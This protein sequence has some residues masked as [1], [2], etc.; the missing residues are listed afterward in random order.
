MRRFESEREGIGERIRDKTAASKR[1]C[2]GCLLLALQSQFSEHLAIFRVE[3]V[4]HINFARAWWEGRRECRLNDHLALPLRVPGRES[5]DARLANNHEQTQSC[6][7]S[8]FIWRMSDQ[9]RWF[10]RENRRIST[11]FFWRL[12][13]FGI[14]AP[15]C[16]KRR[17]SISRSDSRR[18]RSNR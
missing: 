18:G 17:D 11:R 7:Q 1:K 3:L 13:C 4:F 5:P 10:L 8:A 16:R 14:S 15:F 2:G 9:K 12:F 6:L